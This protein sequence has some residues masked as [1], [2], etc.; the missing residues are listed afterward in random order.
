VN[1]RFS[2][3]LAASICATVLLASCGGGGGGGATNPRATRTPD[4][5]TT[6]TPDRFLLFPNPQLLS[7]GTFEMNTVAYATAYYAAIDPNN[8]RDTL[9]KWKTT[10]G[11]GSGTGTEYT[12][13]FGDVR[14]L[15][16]GRRMT[17]RLKPDGT[18]AFMVENYAVNA[19]AGYTYTTLNLEA[20]VIPDASWHIGTNAI[21]FGPGP[22]G[23][24]SFARW[25]TFDPTPPYARRLV[26]NL[27]NRGSKAMPGIC[28]NCHGGR[29]DTLTPVVPATGLPLYA[30]VQNSLS[31]HRGDVQGRLHML[32]LDH[33]DFSP[34]SPYTRAELEANMKQM[35]KL[36][37][38][39]YPLVGAVAGAEDNCRP[40]ATAN[41]YQ[42]IAADVLKA[43]YGGNGLPN[44]TFSDS[45]VPPAW[46]SAGQ[47]TLYNNVLKQVCMT[48]HLLRGTNNQDDLGFYT[49]AKFASYAD[50]IKAHVFDRGNMPLAKIVS[51]RLWSTPSIIDTL[52]GWVE[53]QG[54]TVR[55]SSGAW[56][57]PGRPIADPGPSRVVRSP[58]TLSAAM[59]LYASSYS[60]SITSNPG[61]A[62]TLTNATTSTPTFTAPNGTYVVQL[63]AS[64]GSTQSAAASLTIVVDSTLTPAPSAIRFSDIKTVLQG[65]CV[66]CHTPTQVITASQRPPI[67]YTTYDRNGDGFTDATDDDW[68]YK[69][70]KGRINFTDIV[71]SPL[72]RKPSNNHHNGL[73]QTGFDTS[74]APGHASR[75]NYDMFLN[76]IL[77]GAPQ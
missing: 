60:W 41:E 71:A 50:R 42:G 25:Y 28:I 58:T 22:N 64:E 70:L 31:A 43:A 72:L 39:T 53:G 18:I 66:A 3:A 9:T 26:A 37:L 74:F 32:N 44:A 12:A 13:T 52:A 45:F 16:Y 19:G 8:D 40:A 21:E 46:V 38:C 75:V 33:L 54:Y 1:L 49:Y 5:I 23:G 59:S 76:W 68:F 20:A 47:S 30:L 77:N 7:D 11:F 55:D 14:D 10:N 73:L 34:T 4:T 2:F 36:I 48:C 63:I 15:G 35:N 65:T 69:E 61:G 51:D 29:G 56:L 62:A 57:R 24:T 27:D 6:G 17:A 67:F